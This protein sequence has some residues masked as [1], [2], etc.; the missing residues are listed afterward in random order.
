[1]GAL[2]YALYRGYYALGGTFGMP[3]IPL[4][5]SQWR[6][7]NAIGA[8]IIL[9]GAIVPIAVL[10]AWRRRRARTLLLALCWIVTVGCV[11]HAFV[12]IAERV[13]TVAGLLSATGV[14]GRFIVG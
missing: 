4:S 12:D 6:R 5:E 8:V 7:V 3:G 11:M 9:A 13:L 10:R 2:F 14:I 1:V